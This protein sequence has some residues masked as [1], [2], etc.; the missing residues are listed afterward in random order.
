MPQKTKKGKQRK[1]KFY[2]L[3]K[4]TGYRA[5]SAFKLIQLDRKLRLLESARVAIDLCAAPGGWLQVLQNCMPA[6]SVIIGVD[7][8]P[9]KPIPNVIT[10]QDDITSDSCA[11][12][13]SRHLQTWKADIVLN[14]GA[15]NVGQPRKHDWKLLTEKPDGA[16]AFARRTL[17]T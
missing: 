8:V 12:T 3:A 5:R 6:S 1:D 15:P 16:V 13:I 7:L 10:I 4:E 17:G 9:I 11:A 14:D 2:H